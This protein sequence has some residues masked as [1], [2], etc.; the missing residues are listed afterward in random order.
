[1]ESLGENSIRN[2]RILEYLQQHYSE[3]VT[4][5]ALAA[6][7]HLSRT[8]LSRYFRRAFGMTLMEYLSG[9]RLDYAA[10]DVL[11]TE[12][13][14]LQI[15]VEHGFA[16]PSA[17]NHRFV[18]RFGMSPSVY[19]K[20][21]RK[22]AVS[23]SKAVPSAGSH[24]CLSAPSRAF[25]ADYLRPRNDAERPEELYFTGDAHCRTAA[26]EPWNKMINGGTLKD[27]LASR[28]QN[29]LVILHNHLRFTYVRLW[30]IFVR[31]DSAAFIRLDGAAPVQDFYNYDALD[32]VLDFL[33]EHDM[34][35]FID[36]GTKVSAIRK[37]TT[38]MVETT[39]REPAYP[40]VAVFLEELRA[41]LLHLSGRYGTEEVGLWQFELWS[42]W[43]NALL[44]DPYPVLFSKAY[45]MIKSFFPESL[46]GGSGMH[47][48]SNAVPD[49]ECWA[50]MEVRPDFLSF[51]YFP[52][53]ERGFH[54]EKGSGHASDSDD[55]KHQLGEV[56]QAMT[57]LGLGN[58]PLY[59]TQWS[60]SVSD[61]NF[62]NDSALKGAYI[63]KNMIAA[64]GQ[65]SLAAYWNAS[66]LT[67]DYYDFVHLLGGGPGL[68]TKDGIAKPAYYAFEFLGKLGS[69]LLGKN[70]NAI[71]TANGLHSFYILCHN[72]KAFNYK[73]FLRD[74]S[75]VG[76]EELEEYVVDDRPLKLHFH[77]DHM[78]NGTYLYRK[79][80]VTPKRGS[81]IYEWSQYGYMDNLRREDINHLRNICTPQMVS[82]RFHVSHG[83]LELDVTL[84]ANEIAYI[85]IY[86]EQ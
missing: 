33:L 73:Y 76:V 40:P 59:I 32:S 56:R 13:T 55:F 3:P 66:D 84:E 75:T 1:M 35:P 70:K 79:S 7:V 2:H 68:L 74:E 69:V 23:G 30:N 44:H 61:R 49:L 22:A 8:Y 72:H 20:K 39:V 78:S 80:R 15:A 64:A 52:Y 63:V 4:L 85:H 81:V 21:H 50:Q 10:D 18:E 53:D 26:P 34:K 28:L 45:T 19:R 31:P 11:N 54:M 9:L 57:E 38:E 16:S 27:M 65:V 86:P 58:I 37:N 60:M 6:H 42:P 71:V 17:F 51:Y 48:N 36:L 25:L 24:I 62:F 41:L 83:C 29:H 5:E 82:R 14:V 77:V 67:S 46:V 47:L 43:G 12:K